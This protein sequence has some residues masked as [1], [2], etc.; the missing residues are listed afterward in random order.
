MAGISRAL[1]RLGIRRTRGHLHIPSPDPAYQAKLAWIERA[2]TRA[3]ADPAHVRLLYGDEFSL[4][5]Q[6]SLADVYAPRGWEPTASGSQRSNDRW[7]YSGALDLVSGQVTASSGPKM[8]VEALCAF[9][10][11]LR[12]TYP[13][14]QLFLVWDNWPVH[15]RPP[16]LATAAEERIELLWLPTY[17]PWTNPIE[18]LW[19]WVRQDV[20]HYHRLADQWEELQAQVM[21]FLAQFAHGSPALLG[22]VGL[23]PD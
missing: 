18:K 6:P 19:R 21:T 11:Q 16:V 14:E 10:H 20:V 4:Y 15:T 2:A 5:R 3:R 22:Y 23:L 12:Q 9:L 8:G 13:D 17:A 1:H 7:R